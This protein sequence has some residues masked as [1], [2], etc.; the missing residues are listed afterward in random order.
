ME[1]WLSSQ[2]IAAVGSP[3]AEVSG[4]PAAPWR[5]RRRGG[6]WGVHG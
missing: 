4:I 2:N 5:A 3:D 6:L 1:L